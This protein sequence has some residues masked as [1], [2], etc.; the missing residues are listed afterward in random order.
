MVRPES[1]QF[2]CLRLLGRNTVA[3]PAI[4]CSLVK[5]LVPY[6]IGAAL[7]LIVQV[8]I[9]LYVVPRVQTRKRRED[10]WERN[11]LDLGELLTT[12]VR[13]HAD[14]AYHR[15]SLYRFL[16][17]QLEGV[18][19][20]D[21]AKLAEARQDEGSKAYQATEAFHDLVNTR[22]EWLVDRIK[23]FSDPKPQIIRD[24]ES[25][26]RRYWV[27]AIATFVPGYDHRTDSA[28]HAERKAER[29]TRKALVKQVRRLADLPHPP[30]PPLRHRF[31]RQW[32]KTR[33]WLG[34]CWHKSWGWLN[35]DSRK[36]R[37]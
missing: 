6:L 15:Q 37:L 17:Q 35:R 27:E 16:Q 24:F 1:G 26:A 22:V 12:L 20:I 5:A 32:R 4:S 21:E 25:A 2:A 34:N 29:D 30:R 14:E 9:Q 19:G 28:F 13:Q 36:P 7:T 31:A 10:R 23:S 3:R 11:V 8:V 33:R 18:S